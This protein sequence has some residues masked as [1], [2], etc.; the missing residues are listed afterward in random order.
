[1][2]VYPSLNIY[3]WI[4]ALLPY[5]GVHEP[6][7]S[8]QVRRTW[9]PRSSVTMFSDEFSPVVQRATTPS[10]DDILRRET[11]TAM[12]AYLGR[13]A[14]AEHNFATRSVFTVVDGS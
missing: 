11:L 7:I 6:V 8:A 10:R 14:R 9:S 13:P 4:L 2:R 1:M 3:P 5:T 12:D